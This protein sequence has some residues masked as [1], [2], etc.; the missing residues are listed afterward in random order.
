M[1]NWLDKHLFVG[2]LCL[3]L[4]GFVV[5]E[6]L[7]IFANFKFLKQAV[8]CPH[9]IQLQPSSAYVEFNYAFLK[10]LE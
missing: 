6:F 7:D 4:L 8:Q 9:S 3:V 2:A 5:S 10:A 1:L